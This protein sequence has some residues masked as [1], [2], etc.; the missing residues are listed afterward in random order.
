MA[1]HLGVKKKE[2]QSQEDSPPENELDVLN[3]ERKIVLGGRNVT[4]REYAH[5]EWFSLLG[6]AEP[7][8]QYLVEMQKKKASKLSYEDV[9]LVFSANIGLMLPL[10]L[11]SA[12]MTEEEFKTLHVDEIELLLSAWW[13]VNFRFFLWR[14]QT[15]AQVIKAETVEKTENQKSNA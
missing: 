4:V 6:H 5:V 13:G 11:Q 10:I 3:P 9:L 12:D 14:A 2:T 7:L 1:T 15:R 8:V